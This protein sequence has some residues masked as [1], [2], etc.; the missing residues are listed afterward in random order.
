MPTK[1]DTGEMPSI[2]INASI[3][4]NPDWQSKTVVFIDTKGRRIVTCK[5]YC[6]EVSR[7]GRTLG[8]LTSDII[9]L[10]CTVKRFDDG[11]PFLSLIHI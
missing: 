7:D 1:V 11:V 5:D 4:N 6:I 8:L 3:G 2:E 9:N 10:P